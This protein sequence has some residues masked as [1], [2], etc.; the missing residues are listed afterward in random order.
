MKTD[1]IDSLIDALFDQDLSEADF[2]RLEAELSVSPEARQRYYQRLKLN[3]LLELQSEAAGIESPPAAKVTPT[4][5]PARWFIPAGLAAACLVLAGGLMIGLKIGANSNPAL[6]R[7]NEEPAVSGFGVVAE[8]SEARWAG[9]IPLRKGDLVPGGALHLESGVAQFELFSG[10]SVVVE[11]E[12]QLE[13]VSPMEIDV[14]LGKVRANVPEHAQGFRVRTAKGELVDLGTEFSIDVTPDYA[15]LQ[16]ID[17]EVEWH[18]PS[19]QARN[20]LTGDAVRWGA[21]GRGSPLAFSGGSIADIENSFVE[22]RAARRSAWLAR[23]QSIATDSRVLAHFPMTASA[24]RGAHPPR[25]LRRGGTTRRSSRRAG[26]RTAGN[27]RSPRWTSPPP[28][29]G[30][31]F[32]SPASTARSPSSAGRR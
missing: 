18:P 15:D 30:P 10:V 1:E 19:D 29:A 14:A 11:G 3:T 9:G 8:Q 7:E 6:A 20:L 17:G 28:G 21:D 4:G 23:S 24:P 31:A 22:R 5:S 16:V 25:R 32:R 2:L 13:V 27:T 12:A 26:S